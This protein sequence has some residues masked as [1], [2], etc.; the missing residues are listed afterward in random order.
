ML[1]QPPGEADERR[2]PL[3]LF[4]VPYCIPFCYVQSLP[5]RGFTYKSNIPTVSQFMCVYMLFDRAM[6]RQ[7]ISV[8]HLVHITLFKRLVF[9]KTSTIHVCTSDI[10]GRADFEWS[11]NRVS[12]KFRIHI[13]RALQQQQQRDH[14]LFAFWTRFCHEVE[15]LPFLLLFLLLNGTSSSSSYPF[16]TLTAAVIFP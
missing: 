13:P 2:S 10:E 9:K 4:Y 1:R 12:R 11:A 14:H 7:G 6:T 15:D 8:P 16:E 5:E 3:T